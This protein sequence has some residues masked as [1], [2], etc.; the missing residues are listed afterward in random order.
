[1]EDELG[2]K[3]SPPSIPEDL[4]QFFEPLPTQRAYGVL[5]DGETTI[6]MH[7]RY[8]HAHRSGWNWAIRDREN[9]RPYMFKTKDDVHRNLDDFWI[10][11]DAFWLGY[12]AAM[13]QIATTESTAV[14]SS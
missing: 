10:C 4:E 9:G 6:D 3:Y 2:L 14:S 1:M 5:R 7:T 12:K 13:D 11:Q 8:R